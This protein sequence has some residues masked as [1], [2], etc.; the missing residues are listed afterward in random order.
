M[1]EPS[2]DLRS[3]SCKN[4]KCGLYGKL[5]GDN[6]AIRG[7]YGPQKNKVLLYCRECKRRFAAPRT[8]PF[9]RIRQSPA[10]I[11]K[12]VV[13]YG[14]DECGSVRRTAERMHL[15]KDTVDRALHDAK[16]Y[17]MN[18]IHKILD[19]LYIPHEQFDQFWRFIYKMRG[20]SGRDVQ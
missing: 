12:I 5:G 8:N 7:K 17:C 4:K 18:E 1:D 3:V 15:N 14:D 2:L 9:P 6:I 10:T 20:L 19:S 11:G 13:S 16:K